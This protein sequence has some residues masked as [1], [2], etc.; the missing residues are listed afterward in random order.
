[1][2]LHH[3][4]FRYLQSSLFIVGQ[5]KYIL[6]PTSTYVSIYIGTKRQKVC[7]RSSARGKFIFILPLRT[8]CTIR[9]TYRSFNNNYKLF[10]RILIKK[11]II[12]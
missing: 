2:L 5:I 9:S 4:V 6:Y 7:Y 11:S 3:Y 1:M 8:Y 10:I 12:F